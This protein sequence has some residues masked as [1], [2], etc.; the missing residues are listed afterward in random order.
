VAKVYWD[1]NLFIYLLEDKGKLTARVE[2]VRRGMIER[3]DTLCTA[4]M[5]VGEVLVGPA[6]AGREDVWEQYL[7]FFRGPALTLLPF[8]VTAAAIYSRIRLD[9]TVSRADAVHLAC[10]AAAEI[11]LFITNDDRLS[12]KRIPGIKFIV[13]LS[14]APV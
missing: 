9:R 7:R 10:A 6:M 8:D 2:D 1:T 14:S 3:R 11:D 4:T 13:G 12:K 5:S